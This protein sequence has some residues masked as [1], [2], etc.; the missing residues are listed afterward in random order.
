MLL[1]LYNQKMIKFVG[2]IYLKKFRIGIFIILI[3]I[4]FIGFQQKFARTEYSEPEGDSDGFVEP[5]P[6]DWAEY[7]KPIR[8]Y[9]YY[10]TQA[11]INKDIN[12]LWNRYP[13]LKEN[14]NLE[15]GI[16]AEKQEVESLNKK[17]NL[18][19]ANYNIEG[20]ERLKVKVLHENEAVVFVHGN[21]VYLRDDFEESGSEYF[22]EI[23]LKRDGDSWNVVKTEEYTL[24]EYKAWLKENK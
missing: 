12:I 19:D 15:E 3:S 22:M 11:V 16:N 10:R 13:A 5:E 24:P 21:I 1:L 7:I 9:M 2:R 23:F 14:I 17:F 18:L 6:S 4:L 8:E 20:Y